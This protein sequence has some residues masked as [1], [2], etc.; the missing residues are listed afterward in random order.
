MV[1]GDLL[2]ADRALDE[3]WRSGV[4]AAE[5]YAHAK[6]LRKE[7]GR[8]AAI[9]D[10]KTIV[11]DRRDCSPDEALVRLIFVSQRTNRRLREIAWEVVAAAAA[12]AQGLAAAPPRLYRFTL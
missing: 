1:I 8:D 6:R 10:A 9:E 7:I 12:D 4:G 11:S 2:A 3:A 5:A